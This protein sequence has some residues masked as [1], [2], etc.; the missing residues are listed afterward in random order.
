MLKDEIESLIMRGKLVKYRHCDERCEEGGKE[1]ER[2][3]S[4]SSRHRET[5]NRANQGKQ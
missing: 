4:Y 1:K 2:V 5:S 3:R